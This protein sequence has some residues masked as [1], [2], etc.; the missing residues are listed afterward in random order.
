M[1]ADAGEFSVRSGVELE[2]TVGLG[3]EIEGD[4]KEGGDPNGI[5]CWVGEEKDGGR[6]GR[7]VM[8]ENGSFDNSLRKDLDLD[9]KVDPEAIG[10]QKT[11]ERNVENRELIVENG[12]GYHEGVDRVIEL[13][14][15][16]A[17]FC[18][19][20]TTFDDVKEVNVEADSKVTVAEEGHAE[21][22][23]DDPKDNIDMDMLGEK[24]SDAKGGMCE[25]EAE[26]SK[27]EAN[28]ELSSENNQ[29][30]LVDDT[31]LETFRDKSEVELDS[32]TI[33]EGQKQGGE[34]TVEEMNLE[35]ESDSTIEVEK[36]L[37]T[38]V[39]ATNG[40][41]SSGSSVDDDKK[42]EP[43]IIGSRTDQQ[44]VPKSSTVEC[45]DQEAKI[46][47]NNIYHQLRQKV[48]DRMDRKLET[49]AAT[50]YDDDEIDKN[51]PTL[52]E[53]TKES[54]SMPSTPNNHDQV[55]SVI[56][57]SQ[58]M[59]T[60]DQVESE[61]TTEVEP[62]EE[63]KTGVTNFVDQ[64]EPTPAAEVAKEQKS[65]T[66][67][68]E[69]LPSESSVEQKEKRSLNGSNNLLTDKCLDKNRTVLDVNRRTTLQTRDDSESSE[70]QKAKYISDSDA[71][72]N[73]AEAGGEPIKNCDTIFVEHSNDLHPTEGSSSLDVPHVVDKE[74]EVPIY[75]EELL[76]TSD[77]SD[78]SC[79]QPCVEASPLEMEGGNFSAVDAPSPLD[80]NSGMPVE[81][82][83]RANAGESMSDFANTCAD[84]QDKLGNDVAGS[85][86]HEAE[87]G[88]NVAVTH[89]DKVKSNTS[90][91]SSTEDVPCM[92]VNGN[93][94]AVQ[95]EAGV[96]EGIQVST[97]DPSASVLGGKK[98]DTP[99]GKPQA[100][101]IIRVPRYVD[102][103]L[104]SKIQI[105]QSEVNEKTQ[106][107]DSIKVAIEKQKN[108]K[109][110]LEPLRTEVLQTEANSA[111]ARKKYDEQQQLLKGLQQ[112][113][114]DADAV[115]QNAYGHWRELKNMLIEKVEKVMNLWNNDDE[116]R[117]QYVGS[118]MNSTLRRL[119]TSDGR[120]LGPDEEPPIIRSNQ[121]KGPSFPL[122]LANISDYVPPVA[123]EAKI[124]TSKEVDLFPAMQAATKNQPVK[125][126]KTAKPVSNKTKETVVAKV[127]DR[128]V[129]NNEVDSGTKEEEECIK[130]AEEL[131]KKEE[132]LRKQKAQAELKEQCRLEQRAKAKEAEERKKRQA[133]KAQARA[134][135][136]AQKEAELREKKGVTGEDTTGSGTEE[137]PAPSTETSPPEAAR[138]ADVTATTAPKRPSRPVVTAKQYNKI[139]P[140]PLP[141]RKKGKRKMTTWMWVLLTVIVVLL[142]FLAGSYISISSLTFPQSA[143]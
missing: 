61:L 140:I 138:E 131:L 120:S 122:P 81:S 19:D 68:T 72:L 110:E 135:Y 111:A 137:D 12:D 133:E 35:V 32:T 67:V 84:I 6:V 55:E 23:A 20:T 64:P 114:K 44:E 74:V 141:L 128:E 83:D 108:L 33:D 16:R 38:A 14:T 82:S 11:S 75:M 7:S 71:N 90:V 31:K 98:V 10:D 142:L 93:E 121:V 62:E 104:S 73:K 36:K 130:K 1:T 27:E 57:E 51:S 80:T 77:Q 101:Y 34:T 87:T 15:T 29:D 88:F 132:E 60:K 18:K 21:L 124:E 78:G 45:N 89:V 91:I 117:V 13:A 9:G 58:F 134:E 85:D 43:E 136:R 92:N 50:T 2:G 52:A 8:M 119:K 54:R 4:R 66:L 105:A 118:N 37:E 100:I 70:S 139:Q 86:S 116:F 143:F 41:V 99:S 97:K 65:K 123:L 129:E 106:R 48:V 95:G 5:A 25:E 40:H 109:K 79:T 59:R 3:L 24:E 102:D 22:E 42:Q 28:V 96:I 39:A 49:V 113:F 30:H 76:D 53:V 69:I 126:K 46:V 63:L 56:S 26:R 112:Q 103:Q 107:R 125:P 115:R 47:I 127:L 94:E 17:S